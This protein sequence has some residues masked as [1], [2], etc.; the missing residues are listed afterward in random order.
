MST[1]TNT[2]THDAAPAY[3]LMMV[4]DR[5]LPMLQALLAELQTFTMVDS[6]KARIVSARE[7]PPEELR[8]ARGCAWAL[9]MEAWVRRYSNTQLCMGTLGQVELAAEFFAKAWRRRDQA[10][11]AAQQERER[12]QFAAFEAQR[13]VRRRRWSYDEERKDK[14]VRRGRFKGAPVTL[15]VYRASAT[16]FKDEAEARLFCTTQ[17]EPLHGHVPGFYSDLTWD[18]VFV[19]EPADMVP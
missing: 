6:A 14:Y 17:L 16:V 12:A 2:N 11:D 15:D 4:P 7:L 13:V 1:N 18:E 3:I 10:E 19:I 8:H 5:E 9:V